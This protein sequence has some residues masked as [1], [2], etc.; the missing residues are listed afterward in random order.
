MRRYLPIVLCVGIAA[1]DGG[2][3]VRGTIVAQDQTS[4]SNCTATLK[5]P[6]DALSCC[7][8]NII[9]PPKVNLQFTVA[10]STIHYKLV[11]ACEGFK[12]EAREFTYGKDVLP[13]KPLELG[14]VTLQR[15]PP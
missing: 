8:T 3:R 1:C 15:P 6:S 11:L 7:D 5:G 10:P 4:L 2:F 12:P 14:V 13:S 9:S